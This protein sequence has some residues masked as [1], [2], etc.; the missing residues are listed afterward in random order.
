[1]RAVDGSN[2]STYPAVL[3]G[4]WNGFV[5][6]NQDNYVLVFVDAT[7]HPQLHCS[8]AEGLF[9]FNLTMMMQ[10]VLILNL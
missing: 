5:L 7:F 1:M 6:L 2:M 4:V 10:R 3:D 9:W 8:N